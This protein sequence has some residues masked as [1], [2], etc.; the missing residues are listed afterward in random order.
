MSPVASSWIHVRS[1]PAAIVKTVCISP[2]AT[3]ISYDV[4]ASV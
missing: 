3:S 1:C 2:A 4:T